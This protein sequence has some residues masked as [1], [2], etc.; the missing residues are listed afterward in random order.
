[1]ITINLK[2]SF[3]LHNYLE[4]IIANLT[5][6]IHNEENIVKVTEVHQKSKTNRDAVD[7]II[8]V[9][10]EKRFDCNVEDIVFLIKKL[11]EEKL[12]LS[13]AIED[14]KKELFLNW[15][16]NGRQLSIDC[17][18]EFNKHI[19]SLASNMK[20]LVDLKSTESESQGSDYK[21]NAEGNQIIY[22]YPLV[23]KKVIDY[24]RNIV[25]EQY[26]KLM[27]KAD[28]IS[29]EIDQAMLKDCVKYDVVYGLHDSTEE[30]V[31][32]YIESKR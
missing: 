16:E 18:V 21:F 20:R 27:E 26:K 17:A 25:K 24:D 3:R 9:V 14:A 2:E 32:K 10:V 12:K 13:L 19:R 11:I 22:R 8:D 1:M 29:I 23:K 6:Y 5:H 31:E 4:N 15:Q 28:T 30:I 7:E